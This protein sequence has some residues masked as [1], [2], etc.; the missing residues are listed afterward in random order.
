MCCERCLG[1]V[2]RRHG[3]VRGREQMAVAVGERA[4]KMRALGISAHMSTLTLRSTHV[5]RAVPGV[6]GAQAWLVSCPRL[7]QPSAMPL[8]PS[9]S[10]MLAHLHDD[11]SY[12]GTP[13]HWLIGA[14]PRIGLHHVL[15]HEAA[16]RLLCS[17]FDRLLEDLL[18]H[19][20]HHL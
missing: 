6:C 17:L 20:G 5:L 3:P 1:F 10:L 18:I 15:H 14:G 4:G 19:P 11:L 7:E 12:M 13:H 8:L 2:V 16:A 9:P